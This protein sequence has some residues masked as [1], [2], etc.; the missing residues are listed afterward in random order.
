VTQP[1]YVISI[2]FA[3]TSSGGR[4]ARALACTGPSRCATAYASAAATLAAT[5]RALEDEL[6]KPSRFHLVGASRPRAT[7]AQLSG[8]AF[9]LWLRSLAALLFAFGSGHTVG[10]LPGLHRL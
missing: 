3:I 4:V 9:A 8:L 5:L 7:T 2:S 10:E 1:G 6:L